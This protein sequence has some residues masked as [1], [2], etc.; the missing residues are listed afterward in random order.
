MKINGVDWIKRLKEASAWLVMKMAIHRF[1]AKRENFYEDLAEAIADKESIAKFIQIRKAR[2]LHQKD[3]NARLYPLM[4]SRLGQKGGSLS[5][6]LQGVVPKTD[7]MV[8]AA[9]EHTDSVAQ[10]LKL[11]ALTIAN[12]RR[13]TEVMRLALVGPSLILTVCLIFISIMSYLVIPVFGEIVPPERWDAVG[14]SLYFISY[15]TRHFGVLILIGILAVIAWFIWSIQGWSGLK[16]A[17]LDAYVP[18]RL[19]RDYYGTIFLASL[20]LLLISGETLMRALDKLKRYASPWLR[21]HIVK[22]TRQLLATTSNYGKIFNT[23]V[24]GQELA[25]R[26]I[27]AS[28]RNG[29]FS[30]V[31]QKLGIGGIEQ[32]TKR[33]ERSAKLLNIALFFI[34]GGFV[35]YLLIATV[36]TAQGLSRGLEKELNQSTITKR[37]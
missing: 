26:L 3:R 9:I 12:Q 37:Q 7:E 4:L 30:V 25:N 8:L 2:A 31:V 1:C 23:G 21:W 16:R 11:L 17:R 5:R 14:R 15:I 35:A 33:V 20:G 32:A 24:F 36:M 28:R 19:F 34:L 13:M 27:D 18:Y 6:M 22:M 10:G 29:D